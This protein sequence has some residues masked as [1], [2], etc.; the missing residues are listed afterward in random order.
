[1]NYQ[2]SCL[3]YRLAFWD[4]R[5]QFI[6]LGSATWPSPKVVL[7]NTHHSPLSLSECLC[8]PVIEIRG[9]RKDLLPQFCTLILTMS[10]SDPHLPFFQ[11][12]RM[13]SGTRAVSFPAC[14]SDLFFCPKEHH[15]IFYPLS[16]L[17]FNLS[18]LLPYMCKVS[19]TLKRPSWTQCSLL[20]ISLF[21]FLKSQARSWFSQ[22]WP[23]LIKCISFF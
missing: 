15:V 6:F 16:S 11:S 22:N 9:G 8:F 13:F 18:S 21:L 3:H 10:V 19:P 5:N 12:W 23:K 2:R 7:S 1:M 4:L 20:A 14:W 17:Y